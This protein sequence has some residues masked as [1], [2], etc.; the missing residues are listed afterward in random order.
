MALAF[1]AAVVVG[2]RVWYGLLR[3][4][5]PVD[6]TTVAGVQFGS[7]LLLLGALMWWRSDIDVAIR[8]GRTVE[9]RRE[10]LTTGLVLTVATWAFVSIG[11]AN[12]YSD[13]DLLFEVVLVPVGEELVFRGVLLGWLLVRLTALGT[14][15]DA[16][17]SAVV[18]SA[19]AFGAA[20]A[21]NAFFGA[22]GFALVQ[23]LVGT[24]LGL[25]FGWVRVRTDSLASPILL[26][27][28]V[29]GINLLG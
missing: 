10:V 26:H 23:V 1:S 2:A 5:W 18:I 3:A 12:P 13:A 28:L 21:S 19:V 6:D 16:S 24:A 8:L 17:S 15:P 14:T 4:L 11:G 7:F 25:L 20:H 29:N 9:R 27:A 22:G